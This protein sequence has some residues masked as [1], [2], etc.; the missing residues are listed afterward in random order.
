MHRHAVARLHQPV[1]PAQLVARRMAGDVHQVVVVGHQ[2]DATA[3]QVVLHRADRPFIAGDDAGREDHRVALAQR[4]ARMGVHRHPGQRARG[5]P[6]LPVIRIRMLSSGDIVDVVLAEERR[7]ALRDS[8]TRA[9]RRPGCAGC[10]RPSPRCGRP[11]APRGRCSRPARRCWRSR[12]PRPGRC[13]PRIS[14]DRLWR[15]SAS[16]PEWP[17]TMAL[18]ESHTIA[19]TPRS[20]SA[21]RAASSVGGPTSGCGIQLPVAGVQHDAVRRLDRQRLRFRDGVRHADEAQREGL[22]V[23]RAARRHHVRS[24]PGRATAPRPACGA[25]PRRRTA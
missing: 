9:P 7:H 13:R 19:S 20:P 11:R 15:T 23:D 22:Q 10:G 17:S 3:H 24:S 16:L 12:S 1:Q 8:R 4:H 21:A 6:W 5:S 14:T 25:A 2:L 18:V